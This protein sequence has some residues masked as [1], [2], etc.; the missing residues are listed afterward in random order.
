[1]RNPF[2]QLTAPANKLFFLI[3]LLFFSV[4]AFSQTITG[5]VTDVDKN[6]IGSATVQVKGTTRSTSTDNAGRFSIA[7]SGT[8]VLIFSS[9]GYLRQEVPVEGKQ[10]ITIS[11]PT[12]VRNMEDV[13]VT[14]LGIS[15]RS[16]GLGYSATNVKPEDLTVNRTPN[17]INA[18]EGKIAGV[19]ISSLGTGPAGS[20]KIRIR[21]Q[22]AITGGDNPLI[23]INGVP[24][25]SGNFNGSTVG[26]T[27]GGVYSDG[28]DSYSSINSDDI[29]SMT[30]LKGAPAAALYGS[31]AANGVI[32]ITTK[33]KGKGKGI[34]VTLNTNYTNEA[35]LDYTD[36]Q[37]I[38][39]QGENGL[40]PT[41]PNPTSGQWSFGEKIQPGM[42]HV[43][44]NNLTVPY[45]A[46][47][48]RIK[49]FYRNGHNWSNTVS[50]ESAGEK[51]GIHLSLNNTDNYGITPNNKF[52]RKMLNL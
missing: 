48:S 26:V 1:M 2:K 4:A 27:G 31:R 44:F 11:M 28:G 8:D 45:V 10:S 13:L 52:N 51:G 24:I 19:N 30:F 35:P 33:S 21:G 12:D 17:P 6:P 22:S 32:M 7:A 42:T 47:G 25:N 37:S 16:R 23:V 38:Y 41:T 36:Y 15:K 3:P 9:I 18:L 5:T 29:E 20:S 34:G 43:L 39:G 50:M 40:R 46:Q 49:E 14:A